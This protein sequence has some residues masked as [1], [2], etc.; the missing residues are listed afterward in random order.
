ML[1]R[2]VESRVKKKPRFD[3]TRACSTK[4]NSSVTFGQCDGGLVGV[5][6][7]EDTLISDLGLG[8]EADLGAEVGDAG[9]HGGVLADSGKERLRGEAAKARDA[10]VTWSLMGEIAGDFSPMST[11]TMTGAE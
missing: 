4:I 10:F 7:V 3:S 2:T 6:G 11:L 5:D 8:D 1:R 9:G